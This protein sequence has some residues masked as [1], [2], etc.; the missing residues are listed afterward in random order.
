MPAYSAPCGPVRSTGSAD[1]ELLTAGSTPTLRTESTDYGAGAVSLRVCGEIDATSV[2][3]LEAQLTRLLSRGPAILVLDVSD[4]TFLSARGLAALVQARHTA[5][6]TGVD[7]RLMCGNR[8]V[9]R[10]LE[11]TGFDRY[12]TCYNTR[13]EPVPW[14][15]AGE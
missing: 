9:S 11:A 7:L 4:V 6:R 2:A 1:A 15:R 12:F 8:A 3:R 10:P 14:P 13:H 5:V